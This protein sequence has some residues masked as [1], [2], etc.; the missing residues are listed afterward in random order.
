MSFSDRRR[1]L[2][3]LIA[4]GAASA[5]TGCGF[6]PVYGAG[7][8]RAFE[9]RIRVQEPPGR[10]GH[11]Y[12]RALRRRLGEPGPDAAMTLETRLS[13]GERA[14]AITVED[15][16]TRFDILG[17]ARWRLTERGASDALAAGEAEAA[18]AYNTLARPYAT[19][20][21]ELDAERRLAE[22]LAARVFLELAAALGRISAT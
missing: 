1:A 16:V 7:S 10:S 4:L 8:G 19:R 15:D 6:R 17:A 18:T 11:F 13:F 12:A 20:T 21:A 5:T 22:E 3:A 14:T 9:R 2:A